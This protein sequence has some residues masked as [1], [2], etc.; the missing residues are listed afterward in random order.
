[1]LS[2][3][4]CVFTFRILSHTCIFSLDCLCY[5]S[6][7]VL[8]ICFMLVLIIL[9]VTIT[10][11]SYIFDSSFFFLHNIYE[12]WKPWTSNTI[13]NDTLLFQ[14]GNCWVHFS[15]CMY[16]CSKDF[17]SILVVYSVKCRVIQRLMH[18][19]AESAFMR[20]LHMVI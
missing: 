12:A 2:I 8:H 5:L 4:L 18:A 17:S 11:N 7:S 20:K 6:L 15:V 19:I 16:M 1:M 10:S 3:A 9:V 13:E 14:F